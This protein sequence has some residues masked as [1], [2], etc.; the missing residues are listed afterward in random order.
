VSEPKSTIV[1]WSKVAVVLLLLAVVM[2]MTSCGRQQQE[3]SAAQVQPP[4]PATLAQEDTPAAEE[5]EM[6]WQLESS[7]FEDGANIPIEYTCS[8]EDVSPPL[9]WTAPP[10]GTAQLAL[11]CDDPDAPGGT[12][13]HWVIY[14]MP[15]D[16]RK[17]PRAVPPEETLTEPVIATQ[18]RNDFR[19]VGYR[20]P[21][22]P[23]G[24]PH[25]YSFRLYALSEELDLAPNATKADLVAAMEGKVLAEAKLMGKFAR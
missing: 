7:A 9:S 1:R 17:L 22:P 8:G 3:S 13:V 12:W 21:C 19:T 11:T 23:P 2:A 14:G 6:S 15:A 16:V 18:G 4:V 5:E 20:G 25:R 10:E 24:A